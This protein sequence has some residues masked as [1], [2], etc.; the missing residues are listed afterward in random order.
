MAMESFVAACAGAVLLV[1]W[2]QNRKVPILVL[3]GLA[4]IIAAGGIFFLMVG[5][6]LRL[7]L[8]SIV[9]GSLLVLAPGLMWKGAR[10][11]DAKPAPFAIA[12]LGTAIVGLASGTPSIQDFTGSLGLATGAIYL[13]AVAI[14]LWVGRTERLAARRPIIAFTAVHATVLSIGAY[15]TFDGATGQDAVP[16]VIS[17][18]GVIH[19]ESIIFALG[20]AVFILA[21]VK[22]RN[23][24]VSA[25]VAC[26]DPLTG[27]LNRGAFM[28]IA[29]RIVEHCRHDGTPVSV[30]MFDLDRFKAVNDTY[31]HA[32]GDAVIRKFCEVTTAALRP[33]DALGRIGGEEFAVVLPGSSIE[34]ANVRA[35]R[36]RASFAENCRFVGGHQ[37]N[38][39]VSGGLA[40]ITNDGQ[41]LSALLEYS[42]L[43]LYRAKTEGR[44]R[45]KRADQAE[46]ESGFSTVPRVA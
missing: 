1:A 33:H 15:S 31:G 23:E 22:E 42:D 30:M 21:L 46:P 28:E 39:T 38:A 34:A 5:S 29:G 17:L 36:I 19:F 44:N 16:S 25:M 32:I 3:W 6:A 41:T 11:L 12:L 26:I 27:T 4:N 14:T 9:G 35:E 2:S 7:P 10:T 45:I 13:F 8:G 43:A 24:R 20:T 37:V 40:V 18:F